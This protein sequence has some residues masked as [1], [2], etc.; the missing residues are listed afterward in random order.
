MNIW[1][2]TS[3]RIIK[4]GMVLA[5]L[6]TACATHV[7]L[8]TGEPA[9]ATST[10]VATRTSVPLSVPAI[11][12]DS[13]QCLNRAV[14]ALEDGDYEKAIAGLE[15]VVQTGNRAE[16]QQAVL[17]LL[18][19]YWQSERYIELTDLVEASRQSEWSIGRQVIIVGLQARAYDAQG[20]WTLAAPA[21]LR[22]L[23][24]QGAEDYP[25]RLR[26]AKCLTALGRSDEAIAQLQAVRLTEL[27]PSDQADVWETL[28]GLYLQRQDYSAAVASYD[29]ILSFAQQDS[30]RATL[31]WWKGQALLQAG[32]ESDAVATLHQALEDYPQTWG[33]YAALQ[34][35]DAL[36]IKTLSDLQRG[37]L[38]YQVQEYAACL[39]ALR[40]A[41][42]SEPR[43]ERA[44]AQ[45]WLGLAYHAQG[46]DALAVEAYD[47]VIDQ[48]PRSDVAGDA[49]MAKARAVAALGGDA[50][51]VYQQFV[52]CY[53]AH[54]RA[55]E[56]LWR[57]ATLLEQ[58]KAWTQAAQVY[59][60]LW[61]N[62]PQ[63]SRASEAAFRAALAS[64]VLGD[65]FQARQAWQKQFDALGSTDTIDTRVR[66]LTWLGLAS[67]R[68]GDH[69]AGQMFWMQAAEATPASYYGLRARDLLQEIA[70][71]LPSGA[72]TRLSSD[73]LSEADWQALALWVQGWS[74]AAGAPVIEQEPLLYKAQALWSLGWYDEADVALSA[75][76]E[77]LF[78]PQVVLALARTCIENGWIA[79]SI[80]CAE[81]VLAWGRDAGAGEPPNALLRLIYP[82]SQAR[83]VN[84]ES[85]VC[86]VDPLL[87]E[88][89]MRQESLFDPRSESSAGAVG[90]AQIMP[91]TG[92]WIALRL[93]LQDYQQAWLQRPGVSV[94]FG[95]WYLAQALESSGRNW[96]AA[97]AGYNAG[98]GAVSQWTDEQPVNDPDLFYECIPLDETRLYVQRVYEYYRAYQSVYAPCS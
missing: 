48:Y 61:Q 58:L 78:S 44:T 84:E 47:V 94:R 95:L 87:F 79:E 52:K 42:R 8:L 1:H 86:D 74:P 36:E 56:A 34:T 82:L 31:L 26:L 91:E 71:I 43:V 35:L 64:Y 38:L 46:Q 76:R 89:L 93:G 32:R 14:L 3:T 15:S 81:R 72:A 24:L 70:P 9:G 4:L 23:E 20:E 85:Q 88:A 63:D 59:N 25:A 98:I 67:M 13:S 54:A 50:P 22:Y 51:S 2:N 97:L 39:T 33:A 27:S 80:A 41:L 60:M 83:L 11:A 75:L 45:Y 18:R 21:Y 68:A 77:T 57:A 28:A 69:A 12:F 37:Q 30:Y 62:Y 73:T 6:L 17:P 29:Q 65:Y 90:L 66:L 40:R 7:R 5:V 16:R 53:P 55:A 92:A 10:P 49:W 96:M 19:A